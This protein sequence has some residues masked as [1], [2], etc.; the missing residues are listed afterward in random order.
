[1]RVRMRAYMLNQSRCTLAP[2]CVWFEDNA[3]T[4]GQAWTERA[5][6]L[7]VHFRMFYSR[8]VLIKYF[9]FNLIIAF[10][11]H[12]GGWRSSAA[13]AVARLVTAMS[14][15]M[16][17]LELRV[18]REMLQFEIALSATYLLSDEDKENLVS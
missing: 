4:F 9:I 6:D 5:N 16:A 17:A 2:T 15:G 12:L 18:D 7:R 11:N 8:G 13:T 3:F 10:L 14:S 1:M